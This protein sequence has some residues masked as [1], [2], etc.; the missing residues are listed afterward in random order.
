MPLSPMQMPRTCVPPA[1][2]T[3]TC[4]P[5]AQVLQRTC[6]P[7]APIS[8]SPSS[9]VSRSEIADV[10]LLIQMEV[11]SVS[12]RRALAS[13]H[14]TTL[15]IPM[16]AF[17]YDE[18]RWV[19]PCLT[20]V[21][22]ALA[23]S[24]CP[25]SQVSARN[26][27]FC[28]WIEFYSV[29][30]RR[31]LA[32]SHCTTVRIP[33]RA[34]L[35]DERHWVKSCLT[36]VRRALASSR[37]PV[38][39]VSARTKA[40]SMTPSDG[41][42]ALSGGKGPPSG[43]VKTLGH[44]VRLCA[45]EALP[46]TRFRVVGARPASTLS[47]GFRSATAG[48]HCGSS[49]AKESPEEVGQPGGSWNGFR[50]R[51]RRPVWTRTGVEHANDESCTSP[52]GDRPRIVPDPW[53]LEAAA[54]GPW[55]RQRTELERG[56]CA[57]RLEVTTTISLLRPASECS[58][59]GGGDRWPAYMLPK[60][61]TSLP[62]ASAWAKTTTTSSLLRPASECPHDG[63]GDGL[64]TV[65]ALGF[66]LGLEQRCGASVLRGREA[67]PRWHNFSGFR[68]VCARIAADLPRT[69]VSSAPAPPANAGLQDRSRQNGTHCRPYAGATALTLHRG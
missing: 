61:T 60:A 10:A 42:A 47:R 56:L 31:A 28:L 54:L 14:C 17:L 1:P 39:R 29:S 21:R 33:V 41:D 59:H 30:V 38:S 58:H 3:R 50:P 43:G 52:G 13:S 48:A 4:V 57:T 20:R 69:S 49:G 8:F 18:R 11:C 65:F 35:C 53:S 12:V 19:K 24:R 46:A 40:S 27:R 67:A 37:C 55:N 2:P 68:E 63:D 23:S 51:Q 62:G 16:C 9:F 32:S 22:R 25:V 45:T 64:D 66:E 34:L 5:H 15:R 7:H 36:R 26:I 6:V 44:S